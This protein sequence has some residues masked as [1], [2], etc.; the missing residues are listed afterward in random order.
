MQSVDLKLWKFQW[1]LTNDP[2][3]ANDKAIESDKL[4]DKKTI[5]IGT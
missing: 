1:L 2:A 4:K 5:Q 3:D